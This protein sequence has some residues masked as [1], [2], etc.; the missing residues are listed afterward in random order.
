MPFVAGA[1]VRLVEGGGPTIRVAARQTIR[2]P[3]GLRIRDLKFPAE[4]LYSANQSSAWMI[5]YD[6]AEILSLCDG[7]AEDSARTVSLGKMVRRKRG[8]AAPEL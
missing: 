2:K 3:V 1:D 7:A 5:P 8:A 6:F 4:N